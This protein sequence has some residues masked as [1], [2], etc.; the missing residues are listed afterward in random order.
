MPF[1]APR[2]NN[3]SFIKT[4]N[5][6][7]QPVP[8]KTETSLLG[9]ILPAKQTLNPNQ[10]Q[11]A[12]QQTTIQQVSNT[13]QQVSNTLTVSESTKNSI[14]SQV[15]IPSMVPLNGSF[16]SET[17]SGSNIFLGNLGKD[18]DF[19]NQHN[20]DSNNIDKKSSEELTNISEIRP[21][22]IMLS[23]F[24]PLYVN[25][26]T[27]TDD[28]ELFDVF[29]ESL[30][31]VDST[32]SSLLSGIDQKFIKSQNESLK[33]DISTIRNQLNQ[34]VNIIKFINVAKTSHFDLTNNIY[35]YSPTLFVNKNFS[36]GT[37][38]TKDL[39]IPFAK[40]MESKLN[41]QK[42]LEIAFDE[43][44]VAKN[45]SGTKLWMVAI[46]ELKELIRSHSL[47]FIVPKTQLEQKNQFFSN[48][49]FFP[50]LKSDI[51]VS[52]KKFVDIPFD[53]D[54]ENHTRFKTIDDVFSKIKD[55]D[56]IIA[57]TFYLTIKELSHRT[58]L[59]L[60]KTTTD[61]TVRDQ[62]LDSLFGTYTTSKIVFEKN[63]TYSGTKLSDISYFRDI[64]DA[65]K[66]VLTFEKV[67]VPTNSMIGENY[68]FGN[69]DTENL[70]INFLN[71]NK[72]ND[73]KVVLENLDKTFFDFMSNVALIPTVEDKDIGSLLLEAG[74]LPNLASLD[75][76]TLSF[77]PSTFFKSVLNKFLDKD[78]NFIGG[79]KTKLTESTIP[80]DNDIVALF[81]RASKNDEVGRKIRNVLYSYA[82]EIS[83]TNSTTSSVT[84]SNKLFDII[85][86]VVGEKKSPP[87]LDEF[88]DRVVR[89]SYHS[90]SNNSSTELKDVLEKSGKIGLIKT[91][92][93]ILKTLNFTNLNFLCPLVF[94]GICKIVAMFTNVRLVGLFL[95]K[96]KLIPTYSDAEKKLIE[97]AET[98]RAA[99]N[100]SGGNAQ[101]EAAAF[102][103]EAAA[104]NAV[105]G[106]TSVFIPER[107]TILTE[108]T[109]DNLIDA[110]KK[111]NLGRKNN[112]IS[113][114]EQEIN[115]YLSLSFSV[116][117]SMNVLRSNFQSSINQIKQFD[118]SIIDRISTYLNNDTKKLS[119]LLREP[120][121]LIVISYFEDL[122]KSFQS[123]ATENQTSNELFLK[124]HE[125]LPHSVKIVN[126]LNGF[127]KLPEY[128]K[129]K[130]YNKQ[131]ISIG[132]PPGLLK[133]LF[134]KTTTKNSYANKHNDI[135]KILIYKMDLLNDNIVYLPQSFLF[136]ASR[137]PVR[138]NSL[139][140]NIDSG[141]SDTY[142][143][144]FPT[145]NYS[146]FADKN[147]IKD[148]QQEYWGDESNSFGDEYSFLSQDEKQEV[149]SNHIKSFLLENYIQLISGLKVN[150]SSFVVSS[151]TELEELNKSLINSQV[152]I[153]LNLLSDKTSP[154]KATNNSA[155]LSLPD[156]DPYISR[157]LQPK[158]FDRVYNIIF[159]PEFIVDYE[160]TNSLNKELLKGRSLS[161]L[162]D[163]YVRE[164]KLV[165]PNPNENLFIDADKS[166]QD[167][168]LNSYFVVIESY[169][170]KLELQKAN[171]ASSLGKSSSNNF[172]PSPGWLAAAL[173]VPQD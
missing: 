152:S 139:I 78:G 106:A 76:S 88:G 41:L 100:A 59:T 109:Q 114:I 138:V 154:R 164:G 158:K 117:N 13:N 40:K 148:G 116:I 61:F 144:S 93:N 173:A 54:L 141:K 32:S 44:N 98:A 74:I 36:S 168:S 53:F 58:L 48:E 113:L 96:N 92:A 103:A 125:G 156:P 82:Y 3:K 150:D 84:V 122:Y 166:F 42:S 19:K 25:E 149:L 95:E 29:V 72:L 170:E 5:V 91:V 11:T 85:Y 50:N 119:L 171:I 1:K 46:N 2:S 60:R 66:T 75:V 86:N 27:K 132:I 146:L 16:A 18:N 169:T 21:E 67:S 147:M 20:K 136:E 37:K 111:I 28:G 133:S 55:N 81:E 128:R 142:Y 35:E 22:I 12:S 118:T 120:Q 65:S 105:S 167:A 108:F 94:N 31:Q 165:K 7:T 71:V 101:L 45:F 89:S 69:D 161:Q 57:L 73:F 15:K 102:A 56:S 137:F 99:A 14:N 123:I 143:K 159:D 51:R 104:I 87:S 52:V 8:R 112:I 155:V 38:A 110:K 130:G 131:V 127:F 49:S 145:R 43:A 34:I 26:S 4:G 17:K 151:A 115:R 6:Q 63:Q 121:L 9:Q 68:F 157:L 39:L 47:S 124:S 162:L 134:Y 129:G 80:D 172:S 153:E 126:A 33:K 30:R 79:T 107:L 83:L 163:G 140:K 97:I 160:S 62:L 23:K 10:A 24:N 70:L 64:N 135:F 90:V 77:N